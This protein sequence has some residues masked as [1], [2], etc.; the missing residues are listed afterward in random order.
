[1]P[2]ESLCVIYALHLGD[3]VYRYVGLTRLGAAG[4]LRTHRKIA[5]QGR[6][7]AP[8]YRWMRKHGWDTVQI[9]VLEEVATPHELDDR[10]V[11]W[12]AEL[13]SEGYD[14]LNCTAGGGGMRVV[15]EEVRAKLGYWR[16]RRMSPDAGNRRTGEKHHFYGR[17]H[18]A[19]TR[20]KMSAN[21]GMKRPEVSAKVRAAKLGVPR[22]AQ[23]QGRMRLAGQ[24][25]PHMRWHVAADRWVDDCKYC[26]F[27]SAI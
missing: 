5:R 14:L 26:E 19:E 20:A 10:E 13:L 8:V 12:I 2:R 18:T 7:D 15:S 17:Q 3:G 22:S 1:M 24:M 4:R 21:N 16:G 23:T 11:F 6:I 25:A 27:E 9:D